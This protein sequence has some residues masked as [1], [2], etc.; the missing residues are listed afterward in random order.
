MIDK[1]YGKRIVK[2]KVT[3]YQ[4]NKNKR[5]LPAEEKERFGIQEP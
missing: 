3:K 2:N 1:I 5:R 4:K